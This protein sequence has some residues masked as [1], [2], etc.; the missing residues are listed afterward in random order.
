[1]TATEKKLGVYL[2]GGCGIA[3]AA[4]LDALE[5]VAVGPA[6]H[7][8]TLDKGLHVGREIGEICR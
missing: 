3:E 7:A 1:M 6:D 5:K 4:S 8:G 2:C